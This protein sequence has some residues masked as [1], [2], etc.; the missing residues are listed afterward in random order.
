MK[1]FAK[2]PYFTFISSG[3]AYREWWKY[4]VLYVFVPFIGLALL[5]PLIFSENH[6]YLVELFSAFLLCALIK[7]I[8]DLEYIGNIV[9]FADNFKVKQVLGFKERTFNYED[10]SDVNFYEVSM[11]LWGFL[12]FNRR[13]MVV[14]TMANKMK[15]YFAADDCVA[16][17][18]LRDAILEK[19]IPVLENFCRNK[20]LNLERF[21]FGQNLWLTN[22]KL[23]MKPAQLPLQY[24][25]TS[26]SPDGIIN[27]VCDKG[28]G[29]TKVWLPLIPGKFERI[30]LL[31][32]LLDEV[33]PQY[34]P[35]ILIHAN[36]S[37]KQKTN[38]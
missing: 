31:K 37:N 26:I 38:D 32:Y 20:E 17:E 18:K 6:P 25:K 19:Y 1:S 21:G 13:R 7:A 10:I 9:L 4:F 22:G 3:K 5:S 14:I 30:V 23:I 8:Y 2:V 15:F 12:L 24:A 34:Y 29:N 36:N 28:D 11:K 16:L 35:Q 27:I 33:V